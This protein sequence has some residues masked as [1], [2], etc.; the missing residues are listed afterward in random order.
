MQQL[1]RRKMMGKHTKSFAGLLIMAVLLVCLAGS[2]LGAPSAAV[3]DQWE[4]PFLNCLTGPI[5]SIGEYMAWSAHR[6]AYEINQKGGIKGKPVKIVDYDTGVSPEKAVE[7][8]ARIVNKSLVSLGPV[9]EACIMAAMPLAVRQGLFSMTASTT[10]E[11]STQFFPWTLS[12]Y[13]P[14]DKH[15]APAAAAWAKEQ[16]KMKKV[17]QFVEKW[18]CWPSMADA[19]A[20]GLASVG[21]E[22]FTVEVPTDAVTFG[23]LV[24]R[25]LAQKPDGFMFTCTSEKVAKIIIELEKYGWKDKSKIL[26]FSSADDMPLYTTGRD[27]LNG[28]YI[29]AYFDGAKETPRWKTFKENYKKDHGG[30][31]PT[32]LSTIYYDCVYM[33]KRAIE[34]T[35]VTGDPKKLKA[36]RI[37]I[38]DYIRNMQDFDGIQMAW[39]MKDGIPSD[40]GSFLFVI[41]NGIKKCVT[42]VEAWK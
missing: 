28:C 4:I 25:A 31:D 8:M 16:P 24:V 18:A 41:E 34:E 26:I 30:L 7:Q 27:S 14:T 5:A 6:A 22:T 33:I 1:G 37:M 38:R 39:S 32:S 12:W 17:I 35:D 10:Y 23:P 21:V 15:L 20:D 13:P 19:H 29:Y 11:Y 2:S 40:K 36:E 9:P 3:V 42:Y